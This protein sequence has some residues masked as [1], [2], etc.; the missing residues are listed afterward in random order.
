[1]PS[2]SHAAKEFEGRIARVNIMDLEDLPDIVLA[3]D[4]YEFIQYQWRIIHRGLKL[5]LNKMD[6]TTENVRVRILCRMIYGRGDV[7]C[8]ARAGFPCVLDF[9]WEDYP[10]NYPT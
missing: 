5:I 1:M 7:L 2:T 9:A 3:A 10:P 4:K 6:P 8:I